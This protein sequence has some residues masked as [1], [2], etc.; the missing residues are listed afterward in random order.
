[1]NSYLIGRATEGK[2]E[3][4]LML[5]ENQQYI[6]YNKGS[7]I[8][9][10]LKD[11]IGEDSLNAA[12][13]RYIKKVAFQEPPYTNS[14]EFVGFLKDACP[15][16]LK[17]II[18][19][20]FEEITVYENYIKDLSYQPT[21]DGKYKVKLTLG[22]VKFKVDSIGKQKKV[23]VADYIDVGIFAEK[24]VNG[25][26]EEKELLLKK[27]KM[28]KD[29]KTFEFVVS[30]KPVKAGIDPYGKLID[31]KPDNNKWNF[32]SKPPKVSTAAGNDNMMIML[33]GGDEQ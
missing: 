1:M 25:K 33:G 21:K 13:K 12:L 23:P 19:D 18:K 26:T 8:M 6:H 9:Y 14:V 11:Y 10:A 32:G 30:E 28:D 24:Q 7:I 2:K 22:S 15:D 3:V 27:I 17:Y 29:D 20:M 5:V 4:P 16:S 31:R